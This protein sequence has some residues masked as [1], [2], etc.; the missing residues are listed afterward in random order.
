MLECCPPVAHPILRARIKRPVERES[1]RLL[2][3]V[4]VVNEAALVLGGSFGAPTA[5]VDPF[6]IQPRVE[7]WPEAS[8]ASIYAH[9]S[10]FHAERERLQ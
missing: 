7:D 5:H 3:G 2:T 6:G 4:A 8:K 1:A 9:P 10:G